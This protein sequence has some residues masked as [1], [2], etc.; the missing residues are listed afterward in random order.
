MPE[1]RFMCLLHMSLG[2]HP[3]TRQCRAVD[4]GLSGHNKSKCGDGQEHQP[5]SQGHQQRGVG[6][7]ILHGAGRHGFPD[8]QS[9]DKTL[10]SLITL[11]SPTSHLLHSEPKWNRHLCCAWRAKTEGKKRDRKTHIAQMFVMA[12]REK[13]LLAE[14]PETQTLNP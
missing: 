8:K 13:S 12:N 7:Q 2:W 14:H 5:P 11:M 9:K 4:R 3:F 6:F 1:D 10:C